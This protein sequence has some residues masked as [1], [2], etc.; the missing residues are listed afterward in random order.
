MTL[1]SFAQTEE[2]L[3]VDV[4]VERA[5][6][7]LWRVSTAIR[8]AAGGKT[9][10]DDDGKLLTGN[11]LAVD[12]LKSVCIAATERHLLNPEGATSRSDTVGPFAETVTIDGGTIYFNR[13]ERDS[14]AQ[15]A[16]L[17]YPTTATFPGLGTISTTRGDVEMVAAC[18]LDDALLP[19]WAVL[20]PPA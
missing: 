6:Q 10:V 7:A 17:L 11:A 3:G 1:P 12:L 2:L 9:F 20:S 19:E 14:I 4:P 18:D 15:A 16:A 5:K 13:S 8:A